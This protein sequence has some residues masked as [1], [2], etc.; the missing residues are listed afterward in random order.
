MIGNR[1]TKKHIKLKGLDTFA[2]ASTNFPSY[3]FVI[4]GHKED[5]KVNE[6]KK[7]NPKLIFTGQISHDEV[8]K[9]LQKTKVYCQLSYIESFGMG[10]AEAMSCECIP[11]VTKRGGL[12]EVVGDAGFYAAYGDVK[13]TSEA[14][15]KAIKASEDIGDKARKRIENLFSFEKREERLVDIIRSLIKKC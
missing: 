10:V 11:L 15:D 2:R 1:V 8:K 9:W 7:I 6:L 14:I 13:S 3:D 5:E 12:P 4:I